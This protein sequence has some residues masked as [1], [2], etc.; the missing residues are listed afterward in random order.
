MNK[1]INFGDIIFL[2]NT[3][4]RMIWDLLT[5]NADPD[6]FLDATL[7]DMDFIDA[8]LGKILQE[9][10]E[11]TRLLDR[12]GHFRNL[13]ETERQFA[14]VLRKLAEGSGAMSPSA[15]PELKT[16]VDSI[17]DRSLER[18]KIIEQSF[19]F[20]EALCPESVV[21]SEELNELLRDI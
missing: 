21:S 14:A 15:Y 11:N 5:L 6:F 20:G 10:G 16:K 19:T 12:N 3:R 17:R 1:Q 7:A 13:Q 18:Q 9:L 8:A 2:L 4:I